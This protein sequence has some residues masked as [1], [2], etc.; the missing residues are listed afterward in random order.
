MNDDCVAE[1]LS[2]PNLHPG[3]AGVPVQV[4]SFLLTLDAAAVAEGLPYDQLINTLAI[5][6]GSEFEVPLRHFR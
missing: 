1:V 6:F 3:A 5:A 2:S 4:E